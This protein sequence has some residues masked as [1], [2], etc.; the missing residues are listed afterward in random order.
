MR[1]S[2]FLLPVMKYHY[3]GVSHLYLRTWILTPMC[4]YYMLSQ[5]LSWS[6][7]W[8]AEF[9]WDVS[10]LQNIFWMRG[11]WQ[12]LIYIR[13]WTH[14]HYNSP[15]FLCARLAAHCKSN[16]LL[17]I[18]GHRLN[19]VTLCSIFKKQ[20][21]SPHP[22]LVSQYKEPSRLLGWLSYL[23]SALFT[24]CHLGCPMPSR[25]SVSC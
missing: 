19:S 16:L 7:L 4:T 3:I 5:G 11:G 23:C 24:Q 8:E 20:K 2:I 9:R 17:E 14:N 22:D 18:F 21:K 12:I 15:A 10:V 25:V 1:N 6:V 13:L